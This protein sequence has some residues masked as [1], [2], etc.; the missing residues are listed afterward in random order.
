MLEDPQELPLDNEAGSI[1]SSPDA[2][3]PI[4]PTDDTLELMSN[5]NLESLED[6]IEE[7]LV[8]PPSPPVPLPTLY[9]PP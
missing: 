5:D 2:L 9:L 8:P 3:E 4:L 1:H 7:P 6:L